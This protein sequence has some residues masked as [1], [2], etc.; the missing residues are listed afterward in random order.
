[1][2]VKQQFPRIGPWTY[3]GS[4]LEAQLLTCTME[5]ARRAFPKAMHYLRNP[6]DLVTVDHGKVLEIWVWTERYENATKT[7]MLGVQGKW[8]FEFRLDFSM[9]AH[10]PIHAFGF[11]YKLA[12][13][14]AESMA[15]ASKEATT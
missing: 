8:I 5:A 11:I 4:L 15:T 3:E 10:A 12:Q 2:K 1:M 13:Q 7:C 6:E 9:H 14:M